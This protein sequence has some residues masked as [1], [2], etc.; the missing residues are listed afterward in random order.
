[1]PVEELMKLTQRYVDIRYE[2]GEVLLSVGKAVEYTHN[3]VSG[4]VNVI[5]FACMP[6]NVVSALLKRIK[7]GEGKRLPVLT[8][9]CDGQ[10]SL[11][12][13]MRI[14]AFAEQVKEFFAS[15]RTAQ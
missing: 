12:T 13:R 2:G 14:E 7:E 1:L 3:G 9:P 15:K 10:K 11:G 5:P 6:G 8:V 4:I